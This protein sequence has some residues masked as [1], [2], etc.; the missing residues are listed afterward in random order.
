MGKRNK[1]KKN[2]MLLKINNKK[3]MMIFLISMKMRKLKRNLQQRIKEK[4][5][6][7]DG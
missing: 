1:I 5:G 2:K 7:N 3:M 4:K 6:K